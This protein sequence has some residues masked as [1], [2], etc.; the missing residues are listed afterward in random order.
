MA[1]GWIKICG[2]TSEAAVAAALAAGVDAIGF[3]FAPSVRQLSTAR[4]RE[5]ALP[6]RD[7][8]RCIAVTQHPSQALV[9]DIIQVF[10]PDVLQTDIGDFAGLR[11]P[12]ALPRLP[13]LRTGETMAPGNKLPALLLFEGPRSGT[14]QTSDWEAAAALAHQTRLLLAGGLHQHNVAAA[15]ARVQPH[16]VDTSSGVEERPGIKDPIKIAAFVSAA[17]AAFAN[18]E[19]T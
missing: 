14:G 4:A 16:G 6:A 9:D 13:V 10:R 8:V 1:R 11:L 5:L 3:V 12:D 7:R 2:M 15:I 19:Q 18:M 17:R